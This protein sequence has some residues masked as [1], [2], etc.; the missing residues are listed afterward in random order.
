[1]RKWGM[2]LCHC[3]SGRSE[4]NH[5][6]L[7]LLPETKILDPKIWSKE[8]NRCDALFSHS[9]QSPFAMWE[10][11][12]CTPHMHTY[13]TPWIVLLLCCFCLRTE[14]CH[15]KEFCGISEGC[16][17]KVVESHYPRQWSLSL[18]AYVFVRP[19]SS[20]G[21]NTGNVGMCVLYQYV[22]THVYVWMNSSWL[23]TT[24]LPLRVEV[25]GIFDKRY[26]DYFITLLL[27][28]LC[29]DVPLSA[30]S[31]ESQQGCHS[32]FCIIVTVLP[33]WWH[34]VVYLESQQG[35][36]PGSSCYLH[37]A[38]IRCTDVYKHLEV[39]H[40]CCVI[41]VSWGGSLVSLEYKD[42]EEIYSFFVYGCTYNRS[43]WYRCL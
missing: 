24:Y 11:T 43:S 13:N 2:I 38:C 35:C 41:Y 33:I 16:L 15:S 14:F 27:W 12:F 4:G 7:S 20:N 6:N 18:G 17:Q 5:D 39:S 42:V 3:F 26:C 34:S 40:L 37:L 28:Y 23:R 21:V 19:I 29:D 10:S 9:V 8:S 36:H 30:I 25:C 1:M 32:V 22:C 31:L